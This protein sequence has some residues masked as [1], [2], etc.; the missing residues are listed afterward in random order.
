M[1]IAPLKLSQKHNRPFLN[2]LTT[3][4]KYSNLHDEQR[5]KTFEKPG[6]G[7]D[8]IITLVLPYSR[9]RTYTDSFIPAFVH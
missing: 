1:K 6:D 9:M 7:G 4:L 8:I 2:A 3:F 5:I